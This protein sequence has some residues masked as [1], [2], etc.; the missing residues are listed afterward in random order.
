L[1]L[2]VLRQ[3]KRKNLLAVLRAKNFKSEDES[4][5]QDSIETNYIKPSLDE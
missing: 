1:I 4:I 5:I 3:Q 2:L